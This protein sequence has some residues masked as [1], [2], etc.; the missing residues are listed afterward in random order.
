MIFGLIEEIYKRK[1]R[2]KV[3]IQMNYEH[4]FYNQNNILNILNKT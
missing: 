4:I 1:R 2:F 3:I